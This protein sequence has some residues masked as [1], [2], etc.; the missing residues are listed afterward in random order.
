MAPI[1]HD[2]AVLI[3]KRAAILAVLATCKNGAAAQKVTDQII[4]DVPAISSSSLRSN[5]GNQLNGMVANEWVVRKVVGGMYNYSITKTGREAL[6]CTLNAYV[7]IQGIV[8][9]TNE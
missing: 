5:V 4:H 3:P 9:A 2:S 8:G 7:L 1:N 6:E